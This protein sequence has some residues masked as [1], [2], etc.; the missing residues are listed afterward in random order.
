MFIKFLKFFSLTLEQLSPS[1][2]PFLGIPTKVDVAEVKTLLLDVMMAAP[3][4]NV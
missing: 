3:G 4:L 2:L 1:C